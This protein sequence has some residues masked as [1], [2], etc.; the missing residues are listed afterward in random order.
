MVQAAAARN[1]EQFG[2]VV[3]VQRRATARRQAR[4]RDVML[5]P[6]VGQPGKNQ[7]LHQLGVGEYQFRAR[8]ASR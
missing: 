5:R 7:P 3:R 2:K 4:Q 1:E 6:P 8:Q